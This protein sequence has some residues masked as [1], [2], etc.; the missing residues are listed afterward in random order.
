MRTILLGVILLAAVS[1]SL[2]GQATQEKDQALRLTADELAKFAHQYE[3]MSMEDAE[4]LQPVILDMGVTTRMNHFLM[5]DV[6]AEGE[7]D[8]DL[9]RRHK[10]FVVSAIRDGDKD[11]GKSWAYSLMAAYVMSS[12]PRDILMEAVAPELGPGGELHGALPRN[13]VSLASFLQLQVFLGQGRDPDNHPD[14]RLYRAYLSE[15]AGGPGREALIV[16]MVNTDPAQALQAMA[17]VITSSQNGEEPTEADRSEAV[18]LRQT[19][20]VVNNV[21][22]RAEHGLDN[23]DARI[24]E[25]I[26]Y[27][28]RAVNHEQ[29]WIRLYAARMIAGSDVKRLLP[30][31]KWRKTLRDD[32]NPHIRSVFGDERSTDEGSL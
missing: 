17:E 25:A 9:R 27:L 31:T 28:K 19:A 4:A 8:A 21:L 7:G 6:Y 15:H 12:T 3:F 24:D 14:F 23:G 1:S 16:H 22:W 26:H 32:T 29:W 11:K 5:R 2:H 13:H 20:H 30:T 10:K 18:K